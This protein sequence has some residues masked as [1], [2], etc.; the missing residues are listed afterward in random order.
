MEIVKF[1]GPEYVDADGY[2]VG[3]DV[4]AAPVC[5][6]YPAGAGRIDMDDVDGDTSKL[7]ILAPAGVPVTEGMVAVVRGETYTVVHSPWDWA[8][9]RRRSAVARH[10]PR[11]EI[12]VEIARG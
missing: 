9:G 8:V 5:D 2:L 1:I 10:R 11:V 6:V 3:G 4:V 12:T 7:T